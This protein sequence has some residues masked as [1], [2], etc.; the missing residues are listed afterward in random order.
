MTVDRRAFLKATGATALFVNAPGDLVAGAAHAA[1]S[2]TA[3]WDAGSVRHILPTVSDTRILIKVSL[4]TPQAEAPTLRVGS[5]TVRGQMSDTRGEFWQFHA[6]DLQPGR[7]YRLSLTGN[8]G[9]ALCQPWD[10]ATF[11][12][13]DA[14]P[15]KFR[16]LFLSCVGG[17]EAMRHELVDDQMLAI[18][19]K[20]A[21]TPLLLAG[22]SG[23][24]RVRMYVG[25]RETLRGWRKN[26]S[27][28]RALRGRSWARR[29]VSV[30]E[31]NIVL[32][33]VDAGPLVPRRTAGRLAGTL[34]A[35]SRWLWVRPA[36]LRLVEYAAALALTM[37]LG[38]RAWVPAAAFLLLLVTASHHYDELY[39][40]LGRLA[41]PPRLSAA[42]GLGLV[43]RLVVAALLALFAS[44]P[45]PAGALGRGGLWAFAAAL[46]MLFL[47][48][49]PAR[50]LRE[51][52]RQPAL[53][54]VTGAAGD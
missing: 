54:P 23:R 47:V 19:L 35:T 3:N 18:R 40:V 26:T 10:L 51:V 5:K 44:R 4:A 22:S 43:G 34:G 31:R 1:T 27:A 32:A 41:P 53:D 52:R 9:R 36:V 16:V 7:N 21:G 17:H 45:D 42:L 24:V 11:P 28:G 38:E 25:A 46:G 12:S 29:V 48:V 8:R 14:R 6:T 15:E 50:V 37:P 30:R 39:R 2:T 49:E 13:P 33:Q 20:A